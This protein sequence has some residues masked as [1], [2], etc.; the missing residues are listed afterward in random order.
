[1]NVLG[2][3]GTPRPGGNSELLLNAA[4]VPF[5][6]AGWDITR[7]LLSEKTVAPC[8]GCE[9]CR[10][11][12]RCRINDDMNEL[13]QAF[14]QCD[15]VI[16]A[17]PAYFRNV[18]AQLKAVFDRTYGAPASASLEG[19]LGGAIAVGR[20]TGGGQAIVLN[21][22]YNYYLSCGAL[23]VPGELNGVTAAADKPGDILSQPR[24]LEQAQA[25]G[26]NIIKYSALR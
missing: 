5:A 6:D 9:A 24:R 8:T 25:L 3:S 22:I 17:A 4:L 1:M 20:G 21:I 16:I 14:A 11:G 10:G 23:C 2:I 26:C 13:Y 15:A 19:K 12:G 18:P 7:F